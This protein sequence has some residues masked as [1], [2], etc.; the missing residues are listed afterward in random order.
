MEKRI[1]KRYEV[2][3]EKKVCFCC[4]KEKTAKEFSKNSLL[5]GGL[6]TWC[7]VCC[8]EKHKKSEY[9]KR[10]GEIRKQR[11]K[12]DPIFAKQIRDAKNL[13]R[14]K[15]IVTGLL[16]ACKAR[17]LKKGLEFNLEKTDIIIPEICPVLLKPIVCG[18]KN[19]YNYSPSI[20]RIDNNKGYT[21][22]NI[23]VICKKANTIKNNASKEELLLLSSW[24][25][26]TF[27]TDD[28][29]N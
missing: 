29:E 10:S 23:Q 13:N 6:H 16:A 28:S 9:T 12:T 24:I 3:L 18:N 25:L 11:I 20:D 8:S 15:N 27:N 1:K 26:K 19:D 5:N 17:A 7:K 14:K 4:K 2:T 21:K 22:D